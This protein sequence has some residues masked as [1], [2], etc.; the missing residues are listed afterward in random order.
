MDQHVYS[1]QDITLKVKSLIEAEWPD[2]W[3]EG[4][5]SN[6]K[7]HYS[8]HWYLSLKDD[9]AQIQCVMWRGRNRAVHFRPEDGMQVQCRG[10]LTVYEKQ[11]R[12]QLDVQAMHPVG[13]GD[14]QAAFERLKE[15][16]Y[17]EGLFDQ[18]RK[19]P[20]PPYPMRI[21]IITSPTGAALRDM[22]SVIHRRFPAVGLV[23]RPAPRQSEPLQL[24]RKTGRTREG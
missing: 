15:Q 4:E 16:L 9:Q 23:L 2:V 7:A 22:V 19:R 8:G 14:L 11:G 1:V 3:V 10:A 6:F 17:R 18:D 20:L 5:I 13:A 21:G 12:Y 24:G